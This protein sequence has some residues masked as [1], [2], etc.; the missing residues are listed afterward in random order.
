MFDKFS[1]EKELER[2][3]HVRRLRRDRQIEEMIDKFRQLHFDDDFLP[4]E[5]II[6]VITQKLLPD[7]R[8]LRDEEAERKKT[9]HPT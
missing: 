5:S 1:S 6:D 2:L 4:G 8:R 9:H 7:L 3:R